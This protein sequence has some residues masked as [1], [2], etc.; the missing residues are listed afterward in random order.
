MAAY[1]DPSIFPESLHPRLAA[2]TELYE[3]RQWHQLTQA[4]LAFLKDPAAQLGDSL[5]QVRARARALPPRPPIAPLPS[6]SLSPDPP[7]RAP[8]I[9]AP[10]S[11]RLTALRCPTPA[12]PRAALPHLHLCL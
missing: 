9:A 10:P 2:I 1:V 8:C 11:P 3:R 7:L 12:A 6:L 4:L 5:L